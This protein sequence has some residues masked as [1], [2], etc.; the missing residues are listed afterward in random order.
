LIPPT[1]APSLT[2]ER[3]VHIVVPFLDVLISTEN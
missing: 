1:E 3:I 2:I